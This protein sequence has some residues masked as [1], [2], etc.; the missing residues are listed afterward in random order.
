MKFLDWHLLFRHFARPG[1]VL[2]VA[3][4]AALVILLG[5]GGHADAC[6]LPRLECPAVAELLAEREGYGRAATGGLGGRF[7]TVTSNSD[8]GPGTLRSYVERAREPLWVTFATDMAIELKSQIDVGP[9]I[10]IDGRGQSVTLHDWGLTLANTHNIII[11]HIKIDGRFRQDAQAVNLAPAHDVWLNHL[12]LSRTKDRLVNV[13][14]GSTDVTLS[15]IRFEQHNKV[16]LFNNLVS[17]NLFE[18]YDRDS[19]LRVTLHHSYFVETVQRNPRAQIGT[20][21]IYNNLLENWNSYGMS[22]SLEHRALVEGNIF[23]NTANR[24]CAIPKEIGES[25]CNGIRTAPGKTA[26]ANGTSDQ[27]EYDNTNPKYHYTR[28]W[29]AFLK[30]RDN[31][32][33]GETKA[34]LADHRPEDVPVPPYC[35]TYERADVALAD[36]I[37]DGAGNLGGSMPKM[38]RTCPAG[39]KP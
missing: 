20:S 13:K 7:V 8:A 31:L 2:L 9:N 34:V 24:P 3:G 21:H 36:R 39:A 1:V 15:W 5:G 16:M 17:E 33:L 38:E 12:T 26:L 23:A 25:Y 28:D 35:Y 11:T 19:R 37:R 27:V 32:Y 10:T 22:F 14:A 29:R 6:S 30:I 4:F 18:F